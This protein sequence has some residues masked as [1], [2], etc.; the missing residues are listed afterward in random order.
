ML[1]TLV[2]FLELLP[3]FDITDILFIQ[4]GSMLNTP[5]LPWIF[6]YPHFG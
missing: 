1:L 2:E 4:H 3:V 6:R 5:W